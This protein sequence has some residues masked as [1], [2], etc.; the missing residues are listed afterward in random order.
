MIDDIRAAS[1]DPETL[2]R[3]YQDDGKAFAR[4]YREALVG[5][6]LVYRCWKA[7]LES[8]FGNRFALNG[9]RL[10]V[11]V[12]LCLLSG[13]IA[14][15]F[16]GDGG[17]GTGEVPVFSAAMTA[18]TAM[19]LFTLFQRGWPRRATALSL[20]STG[21]VWSWVVLFPDSYPVARTLCF[22]FAPVVLWSAYGVARVGDDMRNL[23][24]RVEY[25]R[26]FGECILVGIILFLCGGVLVLLVALLLELLGLSRDISFEYLAVFGAAAIPVVASWATDRYSAAGRLAPLVAQLFAPILLFVVVAYMAAAT[27][28]VDSLFTDRHELLVFNILLLSVLGVA[29]FSLTGMRGERSSLLAKRVILWLLVLTAALDLVAVAAIGWRLWAFGITANRMVVFGS[30]LIVLGNLMNIARRYFQHL[31]RREDLAQA[32]ACLARYLPVYTVWSL[33][34]F[35]LFPFIF[36]Y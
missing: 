32:E 24:L 4:D 11:L 5:S 7:R 12:V 26:F 27:A 16:V 31:Y 35:F 29:V 17:P 33:A 19:L 10:W 21:M 36:R 20:L 28:N 18:F 22:L 14:K 13:F 2:E 30:N 8:E 1:S 25:L 3:L 9:H 15:L 6:G 34:V 23:A